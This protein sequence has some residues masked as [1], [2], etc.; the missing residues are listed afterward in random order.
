MCAGT[1]PG[2]PVHHKHTVRLSW[3]EKWCEALSAGST[4]NNNPFAGLLVGPYSCLL[5]SSA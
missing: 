2:T 1:Y 4:S 3:K 5:F